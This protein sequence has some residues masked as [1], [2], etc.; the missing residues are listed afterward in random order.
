MVVQATYAQNSIIDESQTFSGDAT[1][2]LTGTI[3][4]DDRY[5]GI[6]AN[7]G[8]DVTV[9]TTAGSTLTISGVQEGA[10]SGASRFYGIAAEENASVSVIGNLKGDLKTTSAEI[11]F[12]RSNGAGSNLSVRGDVIADLVSETGQI[13]IIDQWGNEHFSIYSDRFDATATSSGRLIGIENWNSKGGIVTIESSQINIKTDNSGSSNLNQGILAYQ[14]T[15]NLIGNINLTVLGG[16]N[17]VYGVDVQCDPGLPYDTIVNLSGDSLKLTVSGDANAFGLRPSGATGYLNVTSKVVDISVSSKDGEA[18]GIRSQ[19]G[20][21]AKLGEG[22]SNLKISANSQNGTAVGILNSTYAGYFGSVDINA[23]TVDVSAEGAT[24]IGITSAVNPLY[25]SANSLDKDGVRIN[26]ATTVKTTST[27]AEGSSI[28]IAGN[29]LQT[30]GNVLAGK[31]YISDLTAES[32]AQNGGTAYAIYLSDKGDIELGSARLSAISDG[33]NAIGIYNK[34]SVV[35]FSGDSV[36]SA[37]TALEGDGTV[38]VNRGASL[39]LDGKIAK[40]TW[41]GTLNVLGKAA[42]G[43]SSQEAASDLAGTSDGTLVL[44]AGS[45]VAGTI[46]VGNTHA[47]GNT[48]SIADSGQ[49]IIR[50]TEGYDGTSPLVTVDKVE[51]ANGSSVLLKNSVLVADGT[52]VFAVVDPSSIQDYIFSTDNLLKKV[53]DNKIV[54]LSAYEALGSNVLIPNL[55]ENAHNSNTLGAR[56]ILEMTTNRSAEEALSAL[57][58]L[59]LMGTAAGLQTVALNSANSIIDV[60][61]SHGTVLTAYSYEKVGADLWIDINGSFSKAGSYSAGPISYGYKS[62]LSGVTVG[63]DYSFGNGYVS[64]LAISF[65][66]GSV[67]GQGNGSGI[68]NDV[69]YYGLNLYGVWKNDY[70]NVIGSVGYLKS[71]NKVKSQGFEGK[72]DAD[73]ISLG[74]RME[75]AFYLNKQIAVTPHLGLRYKHIKTDS[76]EAGGFGYSSKKVNLVEVP[77]GVALN[78]DV[79]LQNGMKVK[80]FLDLTITPNLGDKKV[81]QTVSLNDLSVSD[82]FN[83]RIA[84][85]SVYGSRIGVS[86]EKGNHSLGFNYGISGGNHGRVDQSLQAKYRYQF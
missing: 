58:S 53:V 15:T 50:A 32:T 82:S 24:A 59:A 35:S 20:A 17:T 21:T 4:S 57:N 36:V 66:T 76:Y 48:L 39:V 85:N 26:A 31:V 71:K 67:R 1:I 69:K 29:N 73:V 41:D 9:E 40:D 38:S 77:I 62:D 63:T 68:K 5:V 46:N 49:L 7:Q 44:T 80:P 23:Q 19:Y 72:P 11:R 64:G 54:G 75:K 33:G 55:V 30:G 28:G 10:F 52:P 3:E 12:I 13:I 47:T 79:K 34:D 45:T 16:T 14:S 22:D 65:G 70:F 60:V 25:P 84:N 56:R 2:D 18:A 27:S 51:A 74:V 42:Y 43:M 6:G 61:E 81:R 83:A 78:A 8:Q 37:D 86:A